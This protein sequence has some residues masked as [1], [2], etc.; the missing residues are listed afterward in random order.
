MLTTDLAF[1]EGGILIAHSPPAHAEADAEQSAGYVA[2]SFEP[3]VGA[4][5]A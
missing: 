4:A 5:E 2:V 1:G 3:S